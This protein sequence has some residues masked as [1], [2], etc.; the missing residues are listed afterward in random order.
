MG[1]NASKDESASLFAAI[2]VDDEV[3]KDGYEGLVVVV[4]DDDVKAVAKGAASF[5]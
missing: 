2:I 1:E 5:E 4:V 3:V